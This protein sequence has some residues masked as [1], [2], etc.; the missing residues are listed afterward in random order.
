M[1]QSVSP[2]SNNVTFKSKGIRKLNTPH[3]DSMQKEPSGNKVGNVLGNIGWVVLFTGLL[4]GIGKAV[5]TGVSKC[6]KLCDFAEA[7]ESVN[8]KALN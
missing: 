6:S 1:S 8:S 2:V 7:Q 4:L 5:Q 3:F